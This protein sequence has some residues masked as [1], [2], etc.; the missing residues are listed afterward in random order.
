MSDVAVYGIPFS[1]YTWSARMALSEKG[2]AFEMVDSQ[3]HSQLQNELHP[4]GKVPA[5]RH[6]DFV[7][8]E[9][10]AILRYVD[11]A[12]DGPALQP[13]DLRGLAVMEQWMSV[14]NDVYYDAM[15][16]RLVLER[17]A[18]MIYDRGPD[19]ARIAAALP[20]IVRQLDVLDRRL[21]DAAHLA[22]EDVSLADILLIP[23]IFSV[24]MTPEGDDFVAARPHLARW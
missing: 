14:I 16:R 24:A 22:G 10:T 21:A 3:P 15:I 1:S 8:F 11:M 23:I 17:L 4:F 5:F 18:P 6:G 12:F 20:D 13:A 19:E 2:V 9:T 7:L